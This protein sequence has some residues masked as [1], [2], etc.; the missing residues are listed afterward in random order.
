MNDI[1]TNCNECS[2][3][4]SE[5]STYPCN[6]CKHNYSEMFNLS[7]E[8]RI[9]NL[10]QIATIHGAR[11]QVMLRHIQRYCPIDKRGKFSVEWFDKDGAP[12]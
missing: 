6:Q 1:Y 10:E 11:M 8:E 12:L 2:H 3:Y 9:K 4:D 5:E 7:P